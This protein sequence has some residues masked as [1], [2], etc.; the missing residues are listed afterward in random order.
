MPQKQQQWCFLPTNVCCHKNYSAPKI[1]SK[2]VLNL[3]TKA[4]AGARRLCILT[5]N[6]QF[7]QAIA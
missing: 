6:P 4:S 1:K 5:S 2:E 7:Q 3:N